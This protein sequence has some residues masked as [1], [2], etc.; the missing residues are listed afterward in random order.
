MKRNN[1]PTF[2]DPTSAE[3]RKKYQKVLKEII[4]EGVCPFCPE[5]FK[6]HTKPILKRLN[7]WLITENFSPYEN[8]KFHFILVGKKHK[9]KISELTLT[10]WRTITSLISWA[11][12]KYDIKGGGITMRFGDSLYT[13]AT[14][15]HLHLHLISPE[16]EKGK[17]KTVSFPIG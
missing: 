15:K 13:G 5:T 1:K 2:V 6:W 8:A 14:V 10:D 17:A 12:K 4:T 9:E 16:I 3:G 7:G 11:V